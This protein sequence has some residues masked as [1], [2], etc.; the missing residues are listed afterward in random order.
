MVVEH[1]F[2]TTLEAADALREAISL[3]QQFG[4]AAKPDQA[5]Q[6]D[7][8]WNALEVQRGSAKTRRGT[9]LRERPQQVRLD[10]DRGRVAVAASLTPPARGRLDMNAAK[11]RK[12]EAAYA[13]QLLMSIARALELLLVQREAPEQAAAEWMRV[14][15]ELQEKAAGDRRRY[16]IV[17]LAAL[18]F[19]AIA[20]ATLVYALVASARAR[21]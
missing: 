3:L 13:E 6:M 9:S 4:F 1:T 19:A 15:R 5:F 14:E 18:I 11:L 17:L 21:A 7:A 2:L 10:W 20:I 12:A 8:R 16:R